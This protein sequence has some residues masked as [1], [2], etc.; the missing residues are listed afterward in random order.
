MKRSMAK[1][2][3]GEIDL[4]LKRLW[5]KRYNDRGVCIGVDSGGGGEQPGH[6]P[7]NSWDCLTNNAIVYNE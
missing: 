4:E 1:G 5:R 3:F 6:V 7:S 2:V